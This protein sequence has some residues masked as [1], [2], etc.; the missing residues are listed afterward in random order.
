M[1]LNA[2]PAVTIRIGC[3]R[4]WYRHGHDHRHRSRRVAGHLVERRR[5]LLLVA[6]RDLH[7]V[8]RFDVACHRFAIVRVLE[9]SITAAL[10]AALGQV[11]R[12]VQVPVGPVLD[13][14]GAADL[15]E[16]P[17][18]TRVVAV[19]VAEDQKLDVLRIEAR[20]LHG[21]DDDVARVGGVVHRVIHDVAVVR[22]DD[23]RADARIADPVEVVEHALNAE[24]LRRA[25]RRIRRQLAARCSARQATRAPVRWRHAGGLQKMPTS[26]RRSGSLPAIAFALATHS[27][28]FAFA[29]HCACVSPP[30]RPPPPS[31]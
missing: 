18:A 6:N 10:P 17:A 29:S 8:G 11:G 21:R 16:V 12:E 9:R 1:L 13:G 20:L 14:L 5:H 30:P 19:M 4:F 2:F 15:L 25:R 26:N 28:V 27:C 7:A 23:P 31:G 22:R 24:D 3:S